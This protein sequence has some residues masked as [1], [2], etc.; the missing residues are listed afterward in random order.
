MPS[1]V[2]RISSCHGGNYDAYDRRYLFDQQ[3]SGL[4]IGFYA[5]D[6]G[7]MRTDSR[8]HLRQINTGRHCR[9]HQHELFQSQEIIQAIQPESPSIIHFTT[10]N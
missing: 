8:K 1:T 7:G 5:E 4:W 9:I 3:K 10:K 6:T 2:T